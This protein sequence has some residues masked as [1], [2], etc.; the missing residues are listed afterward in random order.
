MNWRPFLF[1]IGLFVLFR[2]LGQLFGD[3]FDTFFVGGI[4]V[5]FF[6][7]ILYERSWWSNILDRL[8]RGS[9]EERR[10]IMEGLAAKDLAV[11]WRAG[12]ETGLFTVTALP[13]AARFIYPEGSRFFVSVHFWLLT[14][15]AVGFLWGVVR[16]GGEDPANGWVLFIL[17][18]CLLGWAAAL[19][20]RLQWLGRQIMI[21]EYGVRELMNDRVTTD[22]RWNRLFRVRLRRLGGVEFR[23]VDKDRLIVRK[24]LLGYGN[25]I[26]VLSAFLRQL[27]P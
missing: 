9:D 12:Q 1:V 22:I 24:D 6:G 15:F 18:L 5:L 19:H 23:T 17:G 27:A 2:A 25:F 16:H 8:G 10:A 7:G 14:V 4:V 3:S 21:D 20:T 11:A 26:M 13:Q